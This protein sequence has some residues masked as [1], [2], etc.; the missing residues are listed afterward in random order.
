MDFD[1][2]DTV[3]DRATY[4]DFKPSSFNLYTVWEVYLTFGLVSP[5]V[6]SPFSSIHLCAHRVEFRFLHKTHFQFL[7][8]AQNFTSVSHCLNDE[9]HF[10]VLTF[11]HSLD[12]H[13]YICKYRCVCLY[14]CVKYVPVFYWDKRAWFVIQSISDSKILLIPHPSPFNLC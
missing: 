5:A 2:G 1:K 4:T 12:R 10:L 14:A 6:V 9:V 13:V 11:G 3:R 7:I 8:P